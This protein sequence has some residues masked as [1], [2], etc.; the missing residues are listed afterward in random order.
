[1]LP[2]LPFIP[3]INTQ[4]MIA[5]AVHRAIATHAGRGG[6]LCALYAVIGSIVVSECLDR[7]AV[8]ML[9]GLMLQGNGNKLHCWIPDGPDFSQSGKYHCWIELPVNAMDNQRLLHIDFTTRYD[10]NY[11]NNVLLANKRTNKS[12]IW[13]WADEV[14]CSLEDFALLG[15][16][17]PGKSLILP[18]FPIE[19]RWIYEYIQDNQRA[20]S[21]IAGAALK[22]LKDKNLQH[23][24]S[25]SA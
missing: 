16:I 9:G 25:L 3:Q 4:Q 19:G 15:E 7:Q 2:K 13:G 18:N 20:I 17:P 21:K 24:D 10:R 23:R 12:H 8:P 11:R 1:M 5:E 14:R 22:E 6:H